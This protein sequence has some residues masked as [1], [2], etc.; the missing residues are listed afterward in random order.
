MSIIKLKDSGIRIK[1]L[2][3]GNKSNIHTFDRRVKSPHPG[4]K[5]FSNSQKRVRGP[6]YPVEK[7]KKVGRQHQKRGK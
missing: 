5:N 4:G 3:I 6:Q 2:Q 1:E 7:A